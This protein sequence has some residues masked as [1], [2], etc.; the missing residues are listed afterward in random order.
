MLFNPHPLSAL[1]AISGKFFRK[2]GSAERFGFQNSSDSYF[3]E[4]FR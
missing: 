4:K 2:A 1:P 3:S